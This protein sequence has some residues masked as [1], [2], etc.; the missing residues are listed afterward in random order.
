MAFQVTLSVGGNNVGF[1]AIVNDCI[2]RF[3]GIASGNCEATLQDSANKINNDLGPAIQ[4]TMTHVLDTN[5]NVQL[6]V[7]GYVKFWVATTTQCDTVSWNYWQFSPENGSGEK[8]TQ[9]RRQ[10]MNDLVDSVNK[11]ISDTVNEISQQPNY[12]NRIHFVDYDASFE[13]H[14]FCEEGVIEPQRSGSEDRT[15]TFIFQYQTPTGQLWNPDDKVGEVDFAQDWLLGAQQAKKNDPSLQVSEFYANQ[16]I[17]LSQD[18]S[19][20]LPIFIV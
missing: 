5:S 16:P 20:G 13:G 3:K 1:G 14:R 7:T 19:G 11:K 10:K 9:D 15:N 2:Y 17:D 18:F 6:Y 8:M 4:A 12:A